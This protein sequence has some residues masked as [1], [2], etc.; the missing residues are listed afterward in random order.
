MFLMFKSCSFNGGQVVHDQP[1]PAPRTQPV[2]NARSVPVRSMGTTDRYQPRATPRPSIRNQPVSPVTSDG[3]TSLDEQVQPNRVEL[4]DSVPQPAEPADP[5]DGYV[6]PAT[7]GMRN[8]IVDYSAVDDDPETEASPLFSLEKGKTFLGTSQMP[9]QPSRRVELTIIAVRERGRSIDALLS[10]LG[11]PRVK[12]KFTGLIEDDPVHLTLMPERHP[13][14]FGM[15]VTYQPWDSESPTDI[16]LDLD[17]DGKTLV[18]TSVAGEVFEF[19]PKVNPPRRTASSLDLDSAPRPAL[20]GF[21]QSDSAT[22]KWRL[23]RRNST[24][25][26]E[27]AE[28]YWAFDRETQTSGRF[29]WMERGSTYATGN[30]TENPDACFLDIELLVQGRS[31]IYRCLYELIPHQSGAI[32]VCIPQVAGS[33]RPPRFSNQYGNMFELTT[34]LDQ[35]AAQ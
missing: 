1:A 30:Y 3:L 10:T 33:E 11:S 16:S 14:S 19:L 2:F 22:T 20:R 13:T 9:G 5:W 24:R 7:Q 15:F 12:K 18:G 17:D 32:R 21:V 35:G 4:N 34:L 26:S 6:E 31:R 29:T 25:M 8:T 28:T 27:S 23:V